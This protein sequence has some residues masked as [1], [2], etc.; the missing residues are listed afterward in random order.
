MNTLIL[1]VVISYVIALFGALIFTY[2]KLD[3]GFDEETGMRLIMVWAMAIFCGW[4]AGLLFGIAALI[5]LFL[6]TFNWLFK[7]TN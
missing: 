3:N 6:F 5:D 1:L 4:F 7:R 2:Y